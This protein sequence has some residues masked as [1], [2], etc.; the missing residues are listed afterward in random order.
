MHAVLTSRPPD[1]AVAALLAEID[2]LRAEIVRLQHLAD[3][4]CLTR[5]ANRRRIERELHRTLQLAARQDRPAALALLDID[6]LKAINDRHGHL[7]GDAVLAHVARHLRAAFRATDIVGRL[8]GDE[9]ALILPCSDA[10]AA[11]QRLRRCVV[12]LAAAP[13]PTAKGAV[14]VRLSFGVVDLMPGDA[15]A[16]ALHRADAAMY[17]AKRA[18]FGEDA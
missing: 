3:T 16:D 18:P 5:L 8:A 15:P 17:R 9:F 6:G 10:K 4:D 2:D 14:L 1:Q 11:T 12:A 13:V 7:A